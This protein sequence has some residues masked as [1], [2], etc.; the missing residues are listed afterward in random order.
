VAAAALLQS[1]LKKR[2]VVRVAIAL[3]VTAGLLAQIAT[4]IFPFFESRTG[5]CA[6]SSCV[7]PA[8]PSRGHWHGLF[9][10]SLRKGVVRTKRR[11]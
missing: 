10:T 8:S 1:K 5:V 2:H 3:C 7:V 6:W 4:Q 11:A 9:W